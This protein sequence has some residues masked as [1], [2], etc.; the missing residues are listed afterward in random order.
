[1]LHLFE[2]AFLNLLDVPIGASYKDRG[3]RN[4]SHDF[5]GVTVSVPLFRI[6]E[7]PALKKVRQEDVKPQRASAS[8][9]GVDDAL[10]QPL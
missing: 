7:T 2:G 10:H 4:D 9:P 8:Q 3:V 6:P 5:F 1:M